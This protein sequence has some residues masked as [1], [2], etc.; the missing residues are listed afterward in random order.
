MPGWMWCGHPGCTKEAGW[1]P[2]PHSLELCAHM[3]S[4]GSC[5][6]IIRA[7][8]GGQSGKLQR[9]NRSADLFPTAAYAR[10]FFQ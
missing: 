1:K 4:A 5:G 7:A 6:A 2:A 8:E 9:L 10:M 3:A